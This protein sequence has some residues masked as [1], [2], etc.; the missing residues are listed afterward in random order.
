MFYRY[1]IKNVDGEDILY[2]YLTMAYEFS[3]ELGV[4]ASDADIKR[5]TKN[6]VQNNHID[7]QG[8]KAFLVI[9][10]II[11]KTVDLKEEI[12]PIEIIHEKHSYSDSQY[13]VTLE[14]DNHIIVEITLKEYLLGVLA[15]N[16]D[17]DLELETL[18]ALAVLYRTYALKE[19][20]T[21]KKIMAINRF[22]IYKPLSYYKLAW[23]GDYNSSYRKLLNALEETD[24]EFA[25]FDGKYITPFIHICSNGYTSSDSQFPYL[26]KRPSLW[27][28][29]S[30]LFLKVIDY[31]YPQLENILQMKQEEIKNMEILSLTD[32]NRIKNIKVGSH[33]MSGEDFKK[34]LSLPS[35]DVTIIIN[36][37]NIRFITRGYGISLGLS[38]FG[39]NEMAKNHCSYTDIIRYYYPNI[40]IKRFS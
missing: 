39:A 19:M 12:D 2:L 27:D 7:F 13:L 34:L 16:A 40:V 22:Q 20:S 29:A 23:V 8:R 17:I 11:V 21:V 6:F 31:E 37:D 33:I 35:D 26:E 10:G 14:L 15:T 28:Y 30:P 4:E 38:E 5:R 1:E 18:K 36:E 3:K 25:T 24:R 9:D 32:N